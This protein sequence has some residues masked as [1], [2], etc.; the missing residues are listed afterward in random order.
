M[1]RPS[2]LASYDLPDAIASE[3][4]MILYIDPLVSAPPVNG[5][6]V[7]LELMRSG[8]SDRT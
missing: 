7:E 1:S 3:T 2:S 5:D 8:Q 4:P 6:V